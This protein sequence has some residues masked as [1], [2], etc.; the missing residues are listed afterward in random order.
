MLQS[1]LYDSNKHEYVILRPYLFSYLFHLLSIRVFGLALASA[2]HYHGYAWYRWSGQEPTY[3]QVWVPIPGCSRKSRN[4]AGRNSALPWTTS[5]RKW[6]NKSQRIICWGQKNLWSI[7]SFQDI[8]LAPR[9]QLLD[10]RTAGGLRRQQQQLRRQGSTLAPLHTQTRAGRWTSFSPGSCMGQ[11]E[12]PPQT[13]YPP[14]TSRTVFNTYRSHAVHCTTPAGEHH[15][16][17]GL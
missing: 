2:R 1:A 4:P 14:N 6:L 15:N 5:R 7:I 16:K 11:N 12:M 17:E 8:L 13:K 10:R 9:G 3:F